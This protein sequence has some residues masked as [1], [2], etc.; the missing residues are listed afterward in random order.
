MAREMN[1]VPYDAHWPL[2]YENEK[3]T[4]KKALDPI[5]LAIHHFGS[6]SV[7]GMA[8]KPI[9]DAIV[10]V[11]RIESIDTFNEAMANAGYIPRGEQGIAGRRYF[12]RLK[13][14]GENHAAHV[15]IYEKEN[16]HIADELMFRDFLRIDRA[17][18]L[19]SEEIK[20]QA[21]EKYRFSP[22][23]YED[24]KHDC[25]MEIMDRAREYY[26]AK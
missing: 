16:P 3:N 24:A 23:G 2:L 6:T 15:H 20:R 8:A 10:V 17:S 1:V 26:R 22:G 13:E 14:D 12:V 11:D 9:I 5:V 7:V 21:S 19:Q 25:V 4:L 18:F